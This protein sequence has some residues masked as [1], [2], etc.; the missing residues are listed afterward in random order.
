MNAEA[1]SLAVNLAEECRYGTSGYE[2]RLGTLRSDWRTWHN[3]IN[4][5][6]TVPGA[7]PERPGYLK[8]MKGV[9]FTLVLSNDQYDA[10]LRTIVEALFFDDKISKLTDIIE[11]LERENPL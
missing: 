10:L 8:G 7:D 6:A 2:W 5:S 1:D 3:T 11:K 4:F 9:D